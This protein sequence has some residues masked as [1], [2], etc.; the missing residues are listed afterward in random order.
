[1]ET[2]LDAIEKSLPVSGAVTLRIP[3]ATAA[4][5]LCYERGR[6]LTRADRRPRHRWRSSWPA[7]RSRPSG[8]TGSTRARLKPSM[9]G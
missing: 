3:H 5:A 6:V 8:P 1:V 2:L 7:R 4:L 9:A